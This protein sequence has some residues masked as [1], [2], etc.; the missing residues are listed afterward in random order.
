L[1]GRAAGADAERWSGQAEAYE[2]ARREQ[3]DAAATERLDGLAQ[4]DAGN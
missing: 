3:A 1:R 2:Q 4:Q